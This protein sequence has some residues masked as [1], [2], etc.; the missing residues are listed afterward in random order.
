MPLLMEFVCDVRPQISLPAAEKVK[1]T[2][3]TKGALE[4]ICFIFI[5]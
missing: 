1:E 3:L 5:L 4:F 2:C